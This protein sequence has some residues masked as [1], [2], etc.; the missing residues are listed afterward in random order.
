LIFYAGLLKA[1]RWHQGRLGE[2][3][4]MAAALTAEDSGMPIVRAVLAHIYADAGRD[5][6]SR[7]LLDAETSAGFPQ[8]D[9]VLLL[10][11]RITWAETAARLG[12]PVAAEMLYERL[13]PWPDR[14]GYDVTG[15]YGAVAHYLGHLATVLGRYDRAEIHFAQAQIIHEELQAPFHLAR[16]HL[17]WAR[18][19]LAR[20][21]PGG[22]AAA[23]AHLES[24]RDL[25]HRHGCTQVEQRANEFLRPL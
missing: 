25:A 23:R 4:S 14:V 1:V 18:M 22:N 20:A 11:S 7:K 8:P 12:D 21:Q 19:L 13:A 10:A 5:D 17:E 6:D 15:V 24:A 9:D 3:I 2:L 16:T